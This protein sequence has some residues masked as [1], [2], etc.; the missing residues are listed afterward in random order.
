MKYRYIGLFL[1]LLVGLAACSGGTT[2]GDSAPWA[3][4]EKL[5]FSGTI[6]DWAKGDAIAPSDGTMTALSYATSNPD[7]AVLGVGDIE[8]D[9]SF[10]FGLDPEAL[11]AGGGVSPD[12]ALCVGL[13]LSNPQQKIVGVEDITVP[14]DYEDG[15]HA[16]PGGAVFISVGQPLTPS[17]KALYTFFFASQDG[18]V[19]GT[20][21]LFGANTAVDLDLRKGWN[22][23]RRDTSGF[24]TAVIPQDAKWYFFNT[25]T[26]P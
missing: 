4:G 22:S 2:P 24:K 1:T 25:L 5:D 14:S 21:T 11:F 17:M 10:T 20:C 9:S 6:V 7:G 12:Q 13:T 23:V 8:A 19:K 18:T 15:V 26:A 16:R 3:L